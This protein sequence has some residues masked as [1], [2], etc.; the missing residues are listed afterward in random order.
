MVNVVDESDFV[1]IVASLL[2]ALRNEG[3]HPVLVINGGEGAAKTTLAELLRELIDPS[4]EP[5]KGL[6]QTE[7]QLLSVATSTFASTITSLVYFPKTLR[8]PLS[9][10]DRYAGTQGDHQWDR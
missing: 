2:D 6:P 10:V 5:L 7:R 9:D 1:L 8:C 4:W 3:A